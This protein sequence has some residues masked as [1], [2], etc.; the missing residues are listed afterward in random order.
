[1]KFDFMKVRQLALLL[2]AVMLIGVM[3]AAP[4]TTASASYTD[5]FMNIVGPMCTA[6]MRDN[7]ILASFS[8]AQAIWESGWGTSTLA[9]EANALFG[10]RAYGGWDGKIYD[11][12]EMKTYKNWADLKAKKGEAYVNANPLNF[13]RAY[14]SWQESVD[15]HSDLFNTSSIYANLRG[16]YDYKSCCTLVVSDGYCGAP[17]YTASLIATIEQ[18]GLE[19][20]NYDFNS[21]GNVGESAA[22]EASGLPS[23]LFMDTGTSYV[24]S[25]PSTGAAYSVKSSNS[26]VVYVSGT[27]LDAKGEGSAT[28]TLSSGDGSATCHATVKEGYGGV[29]ADGVLVKYVGEGEN[30]TVP[31]EVKSIADG[32]FDG[33]NLKNIVIGDGVTGIEDGAF[34]GMSGF[35]LCSYNNSAVSSFATANLIRYINLSAAWVLDSATSIAMDMPAYTTASVLGI[36]Y[37]S[38]G[39]TVSVDGKDGEELEGTAVVGTG[40][41][42]TVDGVPYTVMVRGDTNGD[43]RLSTADLITIRSYLCGDDSVLPDR[44]YRRAADFNGDNRITTSDYLAIFKES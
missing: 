8:L 23:T 24:L 17:V 7:H 3:S 20:F 26:G 29:V 41:K 43:G 25:A 37:S 19:R 34:E 15:D 39:K 18:Y 9:T 42:L 35:T 44:A 6:D 13:W 27:E 10:I 4:A 38:A 1:M 28:V 14:D 32:A 5:D 33:A 30:Y 31:A 12:D 22:A 40:C 21:S 11:R 2:A 16:N 36:Y